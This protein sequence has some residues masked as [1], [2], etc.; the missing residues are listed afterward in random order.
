MGSAASPDARRPATDFFQANRPD[1]PGASDHW[2]FQPALRTASAARM[3]GAAR[4]RAYGALRQT[5]RIKAILNPALRPAL[6]VQIQDG[7]D[8]LGSGAIWLRHAR[9]VIDGRGAVTTARFAA[10]EGGGAASLLAAAAA[11]LGG[12][13]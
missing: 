12:L 5:G 2:D 8:E 6:A 13:L 1:G 9:H 4:S 10:D 3:A 7:P 11:A